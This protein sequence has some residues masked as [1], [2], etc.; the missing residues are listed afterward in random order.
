MPGE[1]CVRL[2]PITDDRP[3]TTLSFDEQEA[4]AGAWLEAVSTW[5]VLVASCLGPLVG[6]GLALAH[7]GRALARL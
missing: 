5:A 4:A 2:P 3:L 1:R 6:L 7:V